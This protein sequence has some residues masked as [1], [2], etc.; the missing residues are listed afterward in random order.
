MNRSLSVG[1][2]VGVFNLQGVF[3][4]LLLLSDFGVLGQYSCLGGVLGSTGEVPI[5]AEAGLFNTTLQLLPQ[6]VFSDLMP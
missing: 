4:L 3:F 5:N 2:L 6:N 1:V